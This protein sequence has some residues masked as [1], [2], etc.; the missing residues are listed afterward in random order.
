ML[1]ILPAKAE[2]LLFSG[3]RRNNCPKGVT[4]T[5]YYYTI[6]VLAMPEEMYVKGYVIVYLKLYRF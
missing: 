1:L 5:W 6:P 2:F 4:R 3:L